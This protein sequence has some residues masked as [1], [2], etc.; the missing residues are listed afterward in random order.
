MFTVPSDAGDL[1]LYVPGVPRY[2]HSN[3]ITLN[4]FE[5]WNIFGISFSERGEEEGVHY[6]S[7]WRNYSKN[8]LKMIKGTK[9]RGMS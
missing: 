1:D 3:I 4:R 8:C 5:S 7:R 6:E 9:Y 2:L